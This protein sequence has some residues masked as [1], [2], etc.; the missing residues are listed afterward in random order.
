MVRKRNK[1]AR[2]GEKVPKERT[3]SYIRLEKEGIAKEDRKGRR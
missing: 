1:T 3:K 2:D